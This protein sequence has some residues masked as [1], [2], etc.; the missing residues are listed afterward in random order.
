[1][2][3]VRRR[4]C[5]GGRWVGPTDE[6]KARESAGG[7]SGRGAMA[8]VRRAANVPP[9]VPPPLLSQKGGEPH[10]LLFVGVRLYVE[11]L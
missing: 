5:P 8:T 2:M 1:M 10:R 11:R 7:G 3:G 9:G 4:P 6:P